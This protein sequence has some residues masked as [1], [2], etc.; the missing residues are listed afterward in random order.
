MKGIIKWNTSKP[1]YRKLERIE[2]EADTEE[3]KIALANFYHNLRL[4]GVGI[5]MVKHLTNWKW[6]AL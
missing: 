3:E 1:E 2:L 5:L 6:R 4:S